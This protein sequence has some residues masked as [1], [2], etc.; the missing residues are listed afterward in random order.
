[1][2]TE[3]KQTTIQLAKEKLK[4]QTLAQRIENQQK[5][6]ES[7]SKRVNFDANNR[8]IIKYT[9]PDLSEYLDS[10]QRKGEKRGTSMYTSKVSTDLERA[11][12][13]FVGNV[14]VQKGWFGYA[15]EESWANQ[16]ND[17]QGYLQG[18]EEQMYGVYTDTKFI[19]SIMPPVAMDALSLGE[20]IIYLGQDKKTLRPYFRY[21][22]IMATYFQRGIDLKFIKVHHI[23]DMCALEAY[24]EWGES[25][26]DEVIQ[27]AYDN[28]LQSFKFIQ[29]VYRRDDP[30][31]SNIK[32]FATEREFIELFVQKDSQDNRDATPNK[33]PMAGVLEQSGYHSMPFIDWP[34]FLKSNENYGRGPLG[35]AIVTVKRLQ[36][37]HKTMMLKAQRDAGPPLKASLGLKN[38]LNLGPDGVTWVKDATKDI[39]EE[40][41][42]SHSG[43]TSNV[44]YIERT[45]EQ[46]EDVLHLS[47]WLAIS[48]VTKQMQ[49]P[50]TYERIGEKAALLVPRLGLMNS[51]F[52]EQIHDR[53]WEMLELADKRPISMPPAILQWMRTLPEKHLNHISGKINVIYKGPL[54][55]A[56]EH[57]FAQRRIMGN[58]QPLAVL[59][60]FD[61]TGVA[62]VLNAPVAAEHVLDDGGFWHDS[63]RPKEERDAREKLR[64]E[65]MMAERQTEIQ[66]KEAGAMKNVAGAIKDTVE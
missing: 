46:I 15:M 65:L 35:T 55:E 47:T 36:A 61:E 37:E 28:P 21:C 24:N 23:R 9:R 16:I 44:D 31:L 62:D 53:V 42:K 52:L 45:E 56:Q 30:I 8:E 27:A 58:L 14:F 49:N 63:I 18:C 32:Q 40:I 34:Y 41:Y 50:E 4:N 59:A 64:M 11:A 6:F 10:S 39:I 17:I 1:M 5:L 33:N 48:L 51:I 26:S 22:E 29:A 2:T 25:C 38:K 43:Y 19:S 60:K 57:L 54:V 7:D 66:E 13:A 20:G 3:T 12:D